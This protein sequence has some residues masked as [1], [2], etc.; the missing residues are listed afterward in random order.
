MAAEDKKTYGGFIKDILHPRIFSNLKDPYGSIN[1]VI[2]V[3]RNPRE[4]V[5]TETLTINNMYPFQTLADLCTRI[6]VESGTNDEFHPENQCLLK[7]YKDA[8][9]T[10]NFLHGQYRVWNNLLLHNPFFLLENKRPDSAFVDGEGS[11]KMIK[12]LSLMNKTLESTVCFIPKATYELDLFLYNDLYR[13][14]TGMKPMGRPIWE[15][16]M[17]V[18]FPERQ[19]EQEDGSL[20]PQA[21]S[22]KKTMVKRYV[23]R[24][25]MLELIDTHLQETP[26]RKPGESYRDDDINL[27][28][29]RNLRFMWPR[30]YVTPAYKPF[31]LEHV[32]YETL[33]SK[34]VPYIRFYQRSSSPLSK[35]YVEGPEGAPVFEYPDLL[36]QW[37]QQKSL[38]PE[39]SLIMMKVLVRPSATNPLFATMFIHEDGSAKFIVQPDANTKSLTEATDLF[40]L[41]QAL[42]TVTAAIPVLEPAAA[43]AAEAVPMRL[44]TPDNITIE[45]AYIVLSLWLDKEDKRPITRKSINAVLPYYR[46]LFQVAASPLRFQDPIAFIRYKAV[47]NFQTPSKD[48]Q[49]LHRILDL[50]KLSGKTS[51]AD[52]VKFY[53]EEFDVPLTTAQA[54]VKGFLDNMSQYEVIDPVTSDYKLANNPG[55]DVAIFGKYPFYTFHMYRVNSLISLRR[56]YS[57]L[58]LMISLGAEEFS[59]LKRCYATAEQ[60]EAEAEASA[61]AEAEAEVE[62]EAVLPTPPWPEEGVFEDVLGDVGYIEEDYPPLPAS[63]SHPPL[64]ASPLSPLQKLAATT[65]DDEPPEAVAVDLKKAKAK[66]YFSQRLD[67]YDKKLFQ[68]SAGDTEATKYSSMC[69]ANAMKQ[70]AVMSEGEYTRMRELYEENTYTTKEAYDALEPAQ[71]EKITVYW[72]DYPLEK[73]QKPAPPSDPRIEV[74]TTLKYGSNMSKGQAN[75][76]MCAPLWCRKDAMVIL[77]ADYE[78]T[79][80]RKGVLKG[81]NT[82]PF[83]HDGPV[84][85]RVKV[86]EGESV[87]ERAPKLKSA[88]NK[89]HLF[90]R[91]LKKTNHPD[92]LYLPCCFLK[93]SVLT[94][95]NH[96]AFKAE[97]EGA[98]KEPEDD[99]EANYKSK[100]DN[101]KSWYIV[102]AE[103]VPLEIVPKKGP[104]IGILTKQMDAFFA[105]DSRE[106]VVNDHTIWKLISRGDSISASGFLR[107]AVENR[108]RHQPIAFLAAIAPAFDLNSAEEMKTRIRT[109]VQPPIFMSLNYGNFLFDF[110]NPGMVE[111]P[112]MVIRKYATRGLILDSGVGTHREAIVRSWKSYEKFNQFME[113]PAHV[114]EYRQFAQLLSLPG[115]LSPNGLLFIVLEVSSKGDIQLRCP[116]YGVTEQMV[117][118]CDI[119]FL[120]HYSTNV[121][122]PVIYTENIPEKGTHRSFVV[123]KREDDDKWPEIVHRRLQEYKRMCHSSGIGIYTDSPKI[124]PAT[125]IPLSMA[126][127][128]GGSPPYAILRDTY[129]HISGVLFK[130]DSGGIVLVPVIDDGTIHTELKVELDWRNFMT[131]LA[132]ATA[133]KEFYDTRILPALEGQMKE[134]YTI[135]G[136]WRL[137][138]SVPEREDMYGL[139]F[140]NGII[141]PVKKPEGGDTVFESEFV[142]EGQ[143]S[144]WCIDTR[145]VFGTACK[146]D[147]KKGKDATMEIDYKELEEIYE[148]LRFTFANWL[149]VQPPGMREQLNAILYRPTLPLFEKRQRLLIKLGNEVMS[150]LD[151]SVTHPKRK[152]S[153]KRADCRVIQDKESCNNYCSWR[154]GEG[155]CFLHVPNS[156]G[157]V[158]GLMIRRLIEELI[159]FPKKRAELIANKINKYT[160]LTKAFRS[161]NQFV[162]SENSDDWMEFL[163][164]EWRIRTS[165]EPRHYEEFGIIQPQTES[166]VPAIFAGLMDKKGRLHY[167]PAESAVDTLQAL[168]KGAFTE[169]ELAEKGQT[170]DIPT[171]V[172]QEALDLVAR[173]LNTSVLQIAYLPDQPVEPLV[174]KSIVGPDG[175]LLLIVQDDQGD[176]GFL[177]GSSSSIR[178]V[179]KNILSEQ[180]LAFLGP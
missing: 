21:D 18:Y 164:A 141:M 9:T 103:K 171:F 19:K 120:L 127:T 39:E 121:W 146:G 168:A 173:R 104:Q 70:P 74:V 15:G 111:P 93:D 117:N 58:S 78:S 95:D 5:P 145:L 88:D 47:D 82:C 110:F 63:L 66:T 162:V 49:F 113:N 177:S 72:V 139:H 68:Y 38:T 14:Y 153:L 57:M 131:K 137:D 83:C 79:L 175:P 11:S 123:F 69:A 91:F 77:K 148:H 45:D 124:N 80:D 33:V 23:C 13:H 134:A 157:D 125:L 165:E 60:E 160:K 27:S 55:I 44:Y 136:V 135:D 158:K 128:L 179:G 140:A 56:I 147:V 126:I 86:V 17:K 178:P 22:Y 67:Y 35:V 28:G 172:S 112:E 89:A 54:R 32:F 4:L 180:L 94:T 46:P 50:Q 109:V 176:V 99:V 41:D 169:A 129:N 37:S 101:N 142:Q 7:R 62:P 75:I 107:I 59:E 76:F 26:L 20:T 149:A 85:D 29:I 48:F 31:Q 42:Q 81:K 92:G 116:P 155:K 156:P 2:N 167:I 132:S 118:R 114:K 1:I 130:L 6:Y 174:M 97:E 152:P 84:K 115:L 154:E 105:Q 65:E 12:I 52:L 73:G 3:M 166:E 61:E 25:Q 30:P 51:L 96:P 119:A 16:I 163:R 34:D 151:S 87:I 71:K 64:P 170:E 53:M 143:E 108:K 24:Q 144:S 138:R 133:A 8:K 161:G 98:V 40:R 102:G 10:R 90:V 100:L 150:W 122:E 36:L 43:A 106:I 159:R